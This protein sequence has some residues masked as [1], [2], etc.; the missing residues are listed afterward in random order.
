[1]TS[2]QN[3]YREVSDIDTRDL[4]VTAGCAS[5]AGGVCSTLAS[6]LAPYLDMNIAVFI[7][8]AIGGMI[9]LAVS[10]KLKKGR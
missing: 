7:A 1:M 10:R 4:A 9:G 3:F 2:L 5:L 8:G 6:L